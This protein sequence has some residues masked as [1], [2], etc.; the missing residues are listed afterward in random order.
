LRNSF[1][2]ACHHPI[3]KELPMVDGE[4]KNNGTN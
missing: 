3:K 2:Q 4:R 1:A